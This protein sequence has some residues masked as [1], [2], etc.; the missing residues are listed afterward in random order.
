[1]ET[2]NALMLEEQADRQA[3]EAQNDTGA[4]T[5]ASETGASEAV[6]PTEGTE[7]TKDK[8]TE[9]SEPVAGEPAEE[10]TAISGVNKL[11]NEKKEYIS[12]IKPGVPSVMVQAYEM[13]FSAIIQRCNADTDFDA[14]VGQP[15]KTWPKA[16]EYAEEK[17]RDSLNPS[18]EQKRLARSGQPIMAPVD[19]DTM[20]SYV[21]EYYMLDDRAE[22]DKEILEKKKRAEKMEMMKKKTQT[23]A[24][25]SSKASKRVGKTEE[26]GEKQ[27]SLL[28]FLG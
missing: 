24:A 2:R 27:I 26:T 6:K 12:M 14:M 19:M 15:Q 9:T 13:L 8:D 28:D 4:V 17:V 7:S 18:D 20:I 22:Y 3:A 1:M 16:M 10:N 5:T 25:K 21:E 11:E 23:A